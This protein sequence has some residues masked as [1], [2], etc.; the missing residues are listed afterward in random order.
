MYHRA[1]EPGG[2]AMRDLVWVYRRSYNQTATFSKVAGKPDLQ[3][4]LC[5]EPEVE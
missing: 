3:K 2:V 1:T 5:A 4:P